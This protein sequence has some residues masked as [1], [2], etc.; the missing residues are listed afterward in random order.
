MDL[1][2]AALCV[3]VRD[4]ELG[5]GE[6]GG[7]NRGPY[8][9]SLLADLDPPI[10]V[11]APWCAAAVQAWF[12]SA[13]RTLGVRNPLDAVRQEG[14]VQSYY[15]WAHSNRLIVHPDDV[16]PGDLALYQF[17]GSDRWNHIGIVVRSA[18]PGS[19]FF[20]AVEGNTSDESQRDGDQTARK[21]RT[22]FDYPVVF[23]NPTRD[24]VTHE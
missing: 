5:M 1:K 10:A 23:V 24:E 8:V 16:E 7:N 22:M 14:L 3:A 4:A 13:A 19:P 20:E 9:R 6:E 11:A 21:P 15:E 17:S 2:R 18:D 12:D